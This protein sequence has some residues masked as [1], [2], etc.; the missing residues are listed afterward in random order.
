MMF[1]NLYRKSMANVSPEQFVI[2]YVHQEKKNWTLKLLEYRTEMQ[3]ST[4]KY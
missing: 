4:K 2:K 3:L 1:L